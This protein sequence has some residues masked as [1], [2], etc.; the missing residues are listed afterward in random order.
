MFDIIRDD[1]K[2]RESM[3]LYEY[4][5]I[6]K[7]KGK[8]YNIDTDCPAVSGGNKKSYSVRREGKLLYGKKEKVLDK[9]K[10]KRK[11][12][13]HKPKMVYPELDKLIAKKKEREQKQIQTR[14]V[15]F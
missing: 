11:G 2:T 4:E 13:P 3:L 7:N 1:F 5:L 12:K 6:L 15:P 14:T 8:C 10:I 9:K